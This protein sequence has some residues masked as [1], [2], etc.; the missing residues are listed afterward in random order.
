VTE[1]TRA[2]S[3]SAAAMIEEGATDDDDDD[4]NGASGETGRGE[5]GGVSAPPFIGSIGGPLD[6][7]NMDS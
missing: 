1:T 7:G 3:A 5:P 6:A 2:A 4:E